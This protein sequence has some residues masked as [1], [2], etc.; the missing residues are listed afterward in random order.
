MSESKMVDVVTTPDRRGLYERSGWWDASTLCSRVLE[1]AECTPDAVA[2]IDASG[3]HTYR[4][5]ITHAGVAA[6]ALTDRGVGPGQV[7]SVQLPNCYEFAVLALA[8]QSLGAVINPVLT[9]YRVHE[10]VH[11]V[12]TA[13]PVVVV[14]PDS[15]R[16]FDHRQLAGEVLARTQTPFRHVVVGGGKGAAGHGGESGEDFWALLNRTR[17]ANLGSGTA[18][19][20]SELIFT[21][22]TEAQPKG[23]MHTEQTANFSV[24]VAYEDLG[25]TSEDVVWM[26][27]PVGHSTGFNYG[28]RFALYHRL[29]LV[30]QD[31]WNPSEALDLIRTEKCSYTLA[32]TTFLQDLVESAAAQD[33]RLDSLRF[34]GCGGAPVAPALVDA[35][36][37]RG[38]AVLRLYGSTEVLVATWN[39]PQ[40]SAAKRRTTDGNPLSHIDV[41][42][43][44]DEDQP[45]EDQAAELYV[46]GPNTCVGFFD[47]AERTE[48]T[49]GP[50]GW[51]RTGDLVA[52]DADGY[53]SVVGR[54][55]EIIIRGGL[56]IAPREIEELLAVF[57]EVE[58]VAV[59]GLPDQRLGER[60]CACLVL[61]D[62][63]MLSFSTMV[64]RLRATGLATYKLPERLE[65][66]GT[67]P[68]TPSGKV[69]KHRIVQLLVDADKVS[70]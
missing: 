48:A 20:V 2:V 60:M 50:D 40:A 3:R 31:R 29:P 18:E 26:P 6:A 17:P 62:G 7:V 69:Q 33:V 51:L 45:A 68:T 66:L 38:I 12:R 21:S 4:Q 16:D 10:L 14:T 63:M 43:R 56:N 67:L 11:I 9:S 52:I 61:H 25:L 23:V 8:V 59:V 46:R 47:D 41:E 13:R 65:I 5:L 15:Y 39:R 64:E 28:L 32:A 53:I 55:K 34:F 22:G 27:S 70:P 24:R 37:E 57:D 54:K 49:F 44:D 19:V 1:H 30:L 58:R 35:A 42:V 36:A